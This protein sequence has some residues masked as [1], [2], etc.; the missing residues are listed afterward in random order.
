MEL[1]V[2]ECTSQNLSGLKLWEATKSLQQCSVFCLEKKRKEKEKKLFS[3]KWAFLLRRN[4][5]FFIR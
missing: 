3:E 5:K 4:V 2:F 1:A